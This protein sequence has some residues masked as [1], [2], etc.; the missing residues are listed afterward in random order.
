MTLVTLSQDGC[1]CIPIGW[2][3]FHVFIIIGLVLWVVTLSWLPGTLENNGAVINVISNTCDSLDMKNWNVCSEEEKCFCSCHWNRSANNII[4]ASDRDLV[5]FSLVFSAGAKEDV[6]VINVRNFLSKYYGSLFS[7]VWLTSAQ[8][9]ID[10][11][12][13]SVLLAHSLT[14]VIMSA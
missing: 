8:L 9:W 6:S 1:S 13:F 12:C 11:R 7:F 10:K 5:W 2:I 4:L 14:R 3:R